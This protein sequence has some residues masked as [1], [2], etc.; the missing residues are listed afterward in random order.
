MLSI[1]KFGAALMAAMLVATPAAIAQSEEFSVFATA[2][3][4]GSA[5]VDYA[6]YRQ[7]FN[8]L[9]TEDDGRTLVAYDAVREHAGGFLNEYVGILSRVDV[10]RLNRDDQLAFWLNTRN[11][12]LV[13]AIADE[14]SLRGFDNERGTPLSPGPLWTEPRI[15]ING[16]S[17]SIQDIEHEIV[18]AGWES[19]YVIYGFYQALEG[20][21]ALSQTPFTGETVHAALAEIAARFT[22]DNTVFRV[23]RNGVRLGEFYEWYAPVVFNGDTAA[24]LAHVQEASGTDAVFTA[25]TEVRFRAMSSRIEAFRTRQERSDRDLGRRGGSIGRGS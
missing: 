4:D 16:V 12:L 23:R 1:A 18:L 5:P 17:L 8:R 20:G 7:F 22:A 24:L 19:P 21:P 2:N 14:R 10:T 13:K 9:A 6:P 11:I 15:T 25:E 3:E